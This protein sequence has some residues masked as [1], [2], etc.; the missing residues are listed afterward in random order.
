M[1]RV[2]WIR[3]FLPAALGAS[4]LAISLSDLSNETIAAAPRG[5][6]R[7][8]QAVQPSGTLPDAD[9]SDPDDL[10]EAVATV[11]LNYMQASW[12]KV[13][14][15]F[16]DATHSELVADHIPKTKFSRWDMKRHTRDEA[17]K[18]LNQELEP[19]N[20]RLTF[21]G[22][23]LILNGLKEFRHEYPAAVLRGDFRETEAA[24]AADEPS[25]APQPQA[26]KKS[27]QAGPAARDSAQS[28][29]S[30]PGR[31]TPRAGSI[32]QVSGVAEPKASRETE[33]AAD[34]P[35]ARVRTT[36]RL[37]TRDAVAVSRIMY[38]A[39]KGQADM[40]D[41]GPRGLPGFRVRRQMIGKGAGSA[42]GAQPPVRFSIGIDEDKNQLVIEGS[43][44]ESQSVVR[45][46][47]TLDSL[48]R[49]PN[50]TMRAI[51]TTKDAGQL[52]AALQPEL[53]R[54]AT[55]T[56]K[57]ERRAALQRNAAAL[58]QQEEA[59]AAESDEDESE[60]EAQP[61]HSILQPRNNQPARPDEG[62]P[63]G[64]SDALNGSI[65]GE[66][67]VESVPELGI[68]VITGA[69]TDVAAVMAVIQEIEKLSAGAAPEIEAVILRHVASESLA[70]LLTNVYDR[71]GAGRSRPLP[72]Q[73]QG[74]Q[75]SQ[76]AVGVF[77]VARPNAVLI[78]AAKDEM[79]K[80]LELIDLLDQP[81]DPTSEFQ[82]FRL[83]NAVPSQVVEKVEALYPPQQQAQGTQQQSATGLI[84]RVR[85]I[86]DLR[87]NSVI[88]QARPRDMREVALLIKKLDAAD[89]DSV[90]KMRIFR[91]TNAIAEEVAATLSQSIQ[92]V[93]APARATTAPSAAGGQPG[94]QFGAPQ[95]GA[96]TTGG[97]GSAELRE[98][99]SSILQFLVEDGA[100]G[101]EVRS[102]ILADIRITADFR[103]NSIVVTA[104]EDS[105]ELVSALIKQLDKP[106]AAV[107][108][109]KVFKL[110]NSDATGMQQLLERLFGIQRTGQP[111]Q[112]GGQGGQQ[113]VPGL[114]VADAE[115]S[116][117][118]LVPLRFA[119]DVRT[120]TISAI[121]G[122]SAL[123]VVEAV[124]LQL[125][126]SDIRQRQNE[127]YRLKNSPAT[128]VA[129][130]ITNFLTSRRNVETTDQGLVSP[131]E[132]VER[133][134][135]VVAETTSNSLIISATPRYF[136]DIMDLIKKLDRSPQQ[137]LIQGLIVEVTL[138][139]ADEWGLEFGVQDSVLF[140]RSA[141]TAAPQFQTTTTLTP[142][143]TV[144]SQSILSQSAVP[145]YL[146]NGAALG[147]NTTPNVNS[148]TIGSQLGTLFN[149]GLTNSALGFGGLVLQAGSQN[150]NFLLRALAARTRVDVLSRP[151]IR[152][153]DNQLAQIQ[154]G[155]EVP[156]INGFTQS[157][158]AG[159]ITPT[160][161]QR[162]IGIILQVTP[163]ISPDGMVVMEVAARKDS[164]SAQAVSLGFSAAGTAISS[165][166]INTT[167]A[168]TTIGVHSGQT[169]I[170][171]GMITKND[172]VI[173]RKVPL[174][175]EIPI[176]GQA[177]R[178]DYKTMTRTELLIFLT[179]R[180]VHSDEE[181]EMFK[182]IEIE[183]MNFI[184]SEAERMHGPLF[185]SDENQQP[186]VPADPPGAPDA[187][188]VLPK[189]RSVPAPPNPA[190]PSNGPGDP[191]PS[192]E[193]T[194]GPRRGAAP[195]RTDEDDDEDLDAAFIQATSH[196]VP[197]K[198]AG[199]AGRARLSDAAAADKDSPGGKKPLFNPRKKPKPKPAD[200]QPRPARARPL[201]DF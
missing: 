8:A 101:R 37:K 117:S 28:K 13:L 129:Q 94:G 179:P 187:P 160:V 19:Q 155:Q 170:L 7:T 26:E 70:T 24:A 33:A 130:A 73:G 43:P 88:V 95:P 189:E 173:E 21:K 12:K 66:V 152:T 161:Q 31:T 183:R 55:A 120:N 87:T 165:P 48:P 156:R 69:E 111:G 15:D 136:K 119:V 75:Q 53:D 86:D 137:V 126:E 171:G 56:Q 98:V 63:A 76:S 169:V 142:G 29:K 194:R 96:A 116:S 68:L 51:A 105:M 196:T 102:G 103:T 186:V 23:Y 151:Q 184:E 118:M 148:S 45:L 145:G 168:L 50:G 172:Q 197:A 40:I 34:A 108:E 16:C 114:L 36:V 71:Y 81:S 4:A 112:Q 154:V 141:L 27:R 22:N 49:G 199:P 9:P 115:D 67:K 195:I 190:I 107:A 131:F 163:R 89:T 17:L 2:V 80:I 10:T 150:V 3:R 178:Y 52:A 61:Q 110:K 125:D 14:E 84:P 93:L 78:V 64:A 57:S 201:E 46:I 1:N 124:L 181:A 106:A 5:N 104:P 38:K 32:Q 188:T 127:V 47:R 193:Q 157:G 132:Q 109:I 176:I 83:K 146:F 74:S 123:A 185:G 122:G 11:K 72:Q 39:F 138:D 139:N 128:N 182:Q 149:T 97:A 82:V 153:V 200:E 90:H 121:G 144:S 42:T 135:I 113:G 192:L 30:A 91:L 158:T 159:V 175:G 167:N 59:D 6:V 18:I 134:V 162:A 99:K 198:G 20:F 62:A 85:I 60:E 191:S 54:L 143:G 35:A 65:K 166:I 147:N 79:A 25:R 77:P 100:E 41:D 133:E 58:E 177:F 92:N 180:I 164:L 140:K 44:E 174:I